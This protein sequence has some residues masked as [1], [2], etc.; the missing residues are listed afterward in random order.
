M[1]R[2]RPP[3]ARSA[4]S[5]EGS[6]RRHRRAHRGHR[7]RRYLRRC[8]ARLDV[9]DELQ[10]IQRLG[11]TGAGTNRPGRGTLG[12]RRTCS[13]AELDHGAAHRGRH[14]RTRRPGPAERRGPIAHRSPSNEIVTVGSGRTAVIVSPVSTERYSRSNAS[15]SGTALAKRTGAPSSQRS[16]QPA[17][18]SCDAVIST[19]ASSHVASSGRNTSA[20]ASVSQKE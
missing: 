9:G 8:Q 15:G 18:A 20:V 2:A 11:A 13:V 7:R 17:P 4:R 10:P 5:A 3:P 6:P 19:D 14:R 16:I 12:D 1:P